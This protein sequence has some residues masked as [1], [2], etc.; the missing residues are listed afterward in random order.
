MSDEEKISA[1]TKIICTLKQVSKYVPLLEGS[2]STTV[3]K[4]NKSV[5]VEWRNN[6][7]RFG[8]VAYWKQQGSGWYYSKQANQDNLSP[9][10]LHGLLTDDSYIKELMK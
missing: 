7:Q 6:Y 4:V 8:I 1:V 3:D 5:T 9:V 10:I 2:P